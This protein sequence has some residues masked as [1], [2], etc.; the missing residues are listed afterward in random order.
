MDIPNIFKDIAPFLQ[1]PLVLVGFVILLFSGI[2]T[3]L[4]KAGILPSL[5]EKTVGDVVKR[6]LNYAFI[7]ALLVIVLG[8]WEQMQERSSGKK[9]SGSIPRDTTVIRMPDTSR[10]VHT[11][12]STRPTKKKFYVNV[13]LR[14]PSEL[15]DA[16]ILVDGKPATIVA[17]KLTS[18]ILRMEKKEI[19]QRIVVRNSY[20]ECSS[21]VLVD[22][23]KEL[24]PC[25]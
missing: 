18:I 9:D 11:T 4:L 5:P 25:L 3:A 2:L 17:R 15:N 24:D 20:R 19:S 22:G 14:I 8:F 16:E 6:I 1:H 10:T 23:A 13:T 12:D 7:L 21:R